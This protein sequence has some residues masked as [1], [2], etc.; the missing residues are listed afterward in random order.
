MGNKNAY[1]L[2]CMGWRFGDA[3]GLEPLPDEY[4]GAM[5]GEV[6]LL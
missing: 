1:A 4:L 3:G 2:F 6:A 5:V